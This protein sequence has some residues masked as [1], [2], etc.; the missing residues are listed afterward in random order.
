MTEILLGLLVLAVSCVAVFLVVLIKRRG[1]Q[2]VENELRSRLEKEQ[3]GR[4]AAETRLEAERKNLAEQKRLLDEAEEKLKDV[5][6]ALSA[7]ALK[8]NR[9]QFLSHAEERLKPIQE[10]LKDYQKRLREVERARDEAYGGLKEST[11]NLTE[12][13]RLLGEETHYLAAAL[14]SPTVG[15]QWGELQLRRVMEIAGMSRYC[16]FQEQQTATTLEGSGRPDVTVSLPNSRIVIIDSK[17]PLTAYLEA[18]EAPDDSAR[19]NALVRYVQAVRGHIRSLSRKE[20]SKQFKNAADFVVL[21]LPGECFFSAALEQDRT[22]MENAVKARVFLASPIILISL[23]RAVACGWQ[24]HELAENAARIADA[25]KDLYER[26]R[27][28][29]EHFGKVGDGLRRALSAYNDAVGSYHLRLKPGARRLAELRA[30]D[31]R[32]LPEVPPVDDAVRSLP[33]DAE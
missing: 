21:F 33:E 17:V 12:A 23:L 8:D 29:A 28:F 13:N 2:G 16:D 26:L 27:K 30:S 14:R 11:H 19:K 9:K 20:Y 32:E 22:L 4:V 3:A 1:N 15:G 31:G 10:L 18:I 5:F 7:E 6:A 25:G 24:E